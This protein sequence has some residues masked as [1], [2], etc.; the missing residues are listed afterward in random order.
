MNKINLFRIVVGHFDTLRDYSTGKRS[1]GDVAL[2]FG[3]PL[4]VAFSGWFY[5]WGLYVDAL[6]ALIAAFA[7]FAGL[8]LNLLLLIYTFS[9]SSTF[10]NALA[11]TKT[12]FVKELHDNIAFSVLTSI[13]IVIAAMVGV[14]QLRM[15]DPLNQ[16]HTGPILTFVVIYLTANFVLTLLMILK[17]IHVLLSTE[18]EQPSSFRKAS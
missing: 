18:I 5:G 15:K 9:T 10:P 11:K 17:R 6:N 7:I 8:L 14:A 16:L 2:F 13:L 1:W 4:V 12:R 3:L